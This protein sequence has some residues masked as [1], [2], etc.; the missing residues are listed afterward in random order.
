MNVIAIKRLWDFKT[1]ASDFDY[2]TQ[3]EKKI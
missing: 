3:T 1:M 2:I